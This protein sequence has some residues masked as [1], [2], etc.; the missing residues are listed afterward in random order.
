MCV[1]VCVFVSMLFGAV[2]VCGE[3]APTY[4]CAV[5]LANPNP[6]VACRLL[7]FYHGKQHAFYLGRWPDP[8]YDR[9]CINAGT[10]GQYDNNCLEKSDSKLHIV[11]MTVK[12]NGHVRGYWDFE[13]TKDPKTKEPLHY[14]F[15]LKYAY[16]Y[17]GKSMQYLSINAGA[18]Y[19]QKSDVA[20]AE[21]IMYK[22]ALDD[23]Q[24]H[25]CLHS[26]TQSLTQSA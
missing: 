20:I 12:A 19:K 3:L 8:R 2:R 22:G 5:P 9:A 21:F 17:S 7:G 25:F 26:L 6:I 1:C 4:S 13:T 16:H 10:P 18:N 14:G 24:V 11:G 15:H 23:N